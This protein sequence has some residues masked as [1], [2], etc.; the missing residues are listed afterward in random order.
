MD[1]CCIRGSLT[2][3]WVY[4]YIEI[5]GFYMYLLTLLV[6]CLIMLSLCIYL[7]AGFRIGDVDIVAGSTIPM[8]NVGP[9]GARERTGLGISPLFCDTTSPST[10]VWLTPDGNTVPLQT[11]TQTSFIAPP[12]TIQ[13][14]EQGFLITLHRG[15]GFISPAGQYCC[16]SRTNVNERL[17]VTLGK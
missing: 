5:Y 15:D 3:Y 17:C 2:A 14:R 6:F 11:D 16:G 9:G 4:L 1:L 7:T 13:R 8:T 10:A 12:N